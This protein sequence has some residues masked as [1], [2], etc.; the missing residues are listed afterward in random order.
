MGYK[1][2]RQFLGL[3]N[4]KR[5]LLFFCL[6]VLVSPPG[7]SRQRQKT[8]P[9]GVGIRVVN[10]ENL[11]LVQFLQK[12]VLFLPVDLPLDVQ[13]IAD[14][15]VRVHILFICHLKQVI[16]NKG[17]VFDIVNRVIQKILGEF[18]QDILFVI[19]DLKLLIHQFPHGMGKI[20]VIHEIHQKSLPGFQR[21]V[22][23]IANRVRQRLLPLL[24][25]VPCAD[26]PVDRIHLFHPQI[27]LGLL[28][29]FTLILIRLPCVLQSP[30]ISLPKPFKPLRIIFRIGVFQ[31]PPVRFPYPVLILRLL[32]P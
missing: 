32:N 11:K 18:L 27:D 3:F 30:L 9:L 13:I 2:V 31:K 15:G 21:R 5:H 19:Y 6:L 22:Q 16:V 8:Q 24:H 12:P 26:I 7:L 1:P 4:R 17:I 10:A 29:F 28:L 20:N 23:I 14:I 25:V